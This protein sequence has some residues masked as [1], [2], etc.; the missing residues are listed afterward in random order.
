M[1]FDREE[2]YRLATELLRA[3]QDG[4]PARLSAFGVSPAMYE[5][6]TEELEHSGEQLAQLAL[7]P[8]EIVS[9]ADRTG[10][11]ALDIY[12]LQADPHTLR[13][14]CQLW[15]RGQKTE[16]TLIA[17]YREQHRQATLTFRL[18]ETQ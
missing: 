3:L 8:S 9:Q 15:S 5:E 16:L 1:A 18:L 17:D 10:R 13:V 7:A 14:A 4:E 11:V 2:L 12:P 6:I